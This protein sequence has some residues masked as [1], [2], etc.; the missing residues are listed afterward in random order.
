MSHVYI[1]IDGGG[2][3]TTVLAVDE[4][5]SILGKSVGE[6]TNYHSVG[7]EIT[8]KILQQ[9]IETVSNT[10]DSQTEISACF[11]LSGLNTERDRKIYGGLIE[12]SLTA[13][14]DADITLINDV[15]LVIAAGTAK[16]WGIAVIAGTGSH[17]YGIDKNA[18]EYHCGG[19]DWL[20]S[21]EGSA[22][23]MGI[24]IIR[25]VLWERD[26]R[27]PKT[28]LSSLLFN[29]LKCTSTQELIDWV[30]GSA[31]TK[32]RFANLSLLI[33]D[34]LN[35]NDAVAMRIITETQ[36][37]LG[38]MVAAI[39]RDDAWQKEPFEI[40]LSGGVFK[41]GQRLTEPLTETLKA[42]A[43]IA[44]VKVLDKEPVWGAVRLAREKHV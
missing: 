41:I 6:C 18:M 1:G 40:V 31:F 35:S 12:K 23:E 25:A 22:F 9:L 15:R 42:V 8:G 30:Y 20:V 16:D 38:N 4:S 17:V 3:K 5:G 43:P 26:G 34:A 28:Y 7:E 21:D 10:F 27:G 33:D 36:T 2:T 14:A 39:V 32:V 13:F 44:T 37:N 24:K 19:F 29:H 11:G